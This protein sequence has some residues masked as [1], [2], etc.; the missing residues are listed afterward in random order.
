M[1]TFEML[2]FI[3]KIPN[4][5]NEC[6]IQYQTRPA[7]ATKKKKLVAICIHKCVSIFIRKICLTF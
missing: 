4:G 2:W 6:V 5:A 7:M 1:N 3:L